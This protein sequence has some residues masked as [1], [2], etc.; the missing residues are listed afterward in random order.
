M[1]NFWNLSSSLK[2]KTILNMYVYGNIMKNKS[3]FGSEYDVVEKDFIKD[4]QRYPEAKRINVYINSG[5]GEVFAAIAIAQQLKRHPAE[6]HTYAEAMCASAATIIHMAGD[7][8]H[9]SVSGLYMIHLPMSKVQGNK[10]DMAKGIEVLGKVEDLIRMTYKIKVKIT[11]EQLTQMIDHEE[12]LTADEALAYGFADVVDEAPMDEIDKMV[13]NI[14]DD[15]FNYGGVDFCF[16]NFVE[17]DKLRAKLSEV[18]NQNHTPVK[19]EGG[20]DMPKTLEE[21]LASLGEDE[22]TLINNSIAD[23]TNQVGAQLTTL[24]NQLQTVTD[25]LTTATTNLQTKESELATAN[26]KIQTLEAQNHVED[27]DAAFLNSLPENARQA[28]LDARATAKLAQDALDASKREQAFGEFKNTIA[29][30]AGNLPIEDSHVTALFTIKNACPD[31]FATI[32]SLFTVANNAVGLTFKPTG[33]D[34]GSAEAPTSAYDELQQ[35]I[36]ALQADNEGMDYNTAL[37][38][39]A[40]ANPDLYERYRNED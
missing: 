13:K 21:F 4:L 5:G 29:T 28:V 16:S 32:E 11:D 10:H 19:N 39:V 7:V 36:T 6:V 24:T 18:Q 40:A 30:A 31:A 15:M 2:D 37:K 38:N 23:A 26:E 27:E 8:R 22:R 1:P 33:S 14:Q 9:I 34:G 25:Q 3:M 12:W 35:K 17:P 20:K